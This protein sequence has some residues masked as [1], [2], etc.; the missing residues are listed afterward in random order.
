MVLR[1]NDWETLAL[2]HHTVNFGCFSHYGREEK[3]VLICYLISKDHN[4]KLP[5]TKSHNPLQA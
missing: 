3:T 4:K 1:L 2:G 5:S